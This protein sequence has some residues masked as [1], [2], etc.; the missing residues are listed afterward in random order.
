MNTAIGANGLPAAIDYKLAEFLDWF[1]V[2]YNT[3]NGTTALYW[4]LAA[5]IKEQLRE[6]HDSPIQPMDLYSP[7]GTAVYFL[8][9]NG[10][11]TDLEEARKYFKRGQ[12]LTVENISVR[13]WSSTVEFKELP[14]KQFNSVMFGAK[15]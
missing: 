5:T 14:G 13:D 3:K 11:D 9:C 8:D 4:Q 2:H 6:R 1:D 15:E 10:Y 12:L 7:S